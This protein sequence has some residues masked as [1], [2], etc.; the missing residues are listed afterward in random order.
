MAR[1]MGGNK[2]P[3]IPY[4]LNSI[5]AQKNVRKPDTEEREIMRDDELAAMEPSSR[6]EQARF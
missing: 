5:L 3:P 6:R 4:L 1:L 2:L